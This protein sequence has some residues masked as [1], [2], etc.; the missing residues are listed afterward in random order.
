MSAPGAVAGEAAP[1]RK[2]GRPRTHTAD[3]GTSRAVRNRASAARSRQ[4]RDAYV[5][6]LESEVAALQ[7][8]L[9][10][11]EE[12]LRSATVEKK[13]RA[14]ECLRLKAELA[15]C[16]RGAGGASTGPGR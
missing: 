12:Q 7:D 11:R 8:A 5:S 16:G 13:A 3:D 9:S 10:E 15:K 2:R 4:R 6:Q 1:K 14:E